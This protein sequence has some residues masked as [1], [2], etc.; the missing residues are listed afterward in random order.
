MKERRRTKFGKEVGDIKF[1]GPGNPREAISFLDAIRS[2][3][4]VVGAN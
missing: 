1:R 2:K 4:Q 3:S